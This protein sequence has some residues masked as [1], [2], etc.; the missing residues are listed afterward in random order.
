MLIKESDDCDPTK[1]EVNGDDCGSSDSRI[2]VECTNLPRML[3]MRISKQR[4]RR[5][6]KAANDAISF[7]RAVPSGVQ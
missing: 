1:V 5:E 2:Y 4:K 7:D 3:R 6:K